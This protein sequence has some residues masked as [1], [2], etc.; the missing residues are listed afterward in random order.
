[1]LFPAARMFFARMLTTGSFPTD[2]ISLLTLLKT[3]AQ[4]IVTT[5]LTKEK[6]KL[7]LHH[8]WAMQPQDQSKKE[9]GKENL[10][11]TAVKGRCFLHIFLWENC[12]EQEDQ[13]EFTPS[14]PNM[15]CRNIFY[16]KSFSGFLGKIFFQ[17]FVIFLR[18][19]SCHIVSA[20]TSI[21]HTPHFTKNMRV[22]GT[23]F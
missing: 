13:V 4:K 1:M 12:D 9:A 17:I 2:A 8:W 5:L 20:T 14:Q 10:F 3:C 15:F 23:F 7:R 11:A 19:C 6:K 21:Q 16:L 22:L 18:L